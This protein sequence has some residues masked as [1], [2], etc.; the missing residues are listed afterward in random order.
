[1]SNHTLSRAAAYSA[2]DQR[3]EI[4]RAAGSQTKTP[5]FCG[6]LFGEGS[7]RFTATTLGVSYLVFL[8]ILN[9]WVVT[10]LGLRS[11]GRV[12]PYFVS[13]SDFGFVR[14]ALLGTLLSLTKLNTIFTNEYAF[15]IVCFALMGALAYFLT[16]LILRGGA[17]S[18][19]FVIA[20]AFSPAFLLHLGYA[21]SSQDLP[22][23]L[24]VLAAV[25]LRK[26]L[27]SL[28]ILVCIGIMLHEI[29]LF[30]IPFILVV[31]WGEG[32][33]VTSA[34]WSRKNIVSLAS[35]LLAAII[36]YGSLKVFGAAHFDESQYY[37]VMALRMP[38]AAHKNVFWSGYFELFSTYSENVT[39]IPAFLKEHY[40]SFFSYLSLL[41][42][43][44]ALF[45]CYI[46]VWKSPRLDLFAK[47][48]VTAAEL[49]PFMIIVV[50][51]DLLRWY[52]FSGT[53]ALL[54]LI[55]FAQNGYV[56][57]SQ[58]TVSVMLAFCVLAPFGEVAI[59]Y[60]FPIL[61]FFGNKIWLLM[62]HPLV[63]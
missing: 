8:L 24:T 58:A 3:A 4:T 33:L 41:A 17:Y 12:W 27:P 6:W 11:F 21:N 61:F 25:I 14:R 47:L 2:F 53:A 45:L 9:R 19:A 5:P 35:I 44:Y 1:M 13:Y 57:V 18:R 37:N 59:D 46:G 52:S 51:T 26:S 56:D 28:C 60:P 63:G 16:Y 54:I 48:I 23:L 32:G 40:N 62:S 7:D 39:D 55:R 10:P 36:A 43:A 50:A 31:R 34:R 29:F 15:A 42:V 30:L 38:N 49:F 22:V 20:A